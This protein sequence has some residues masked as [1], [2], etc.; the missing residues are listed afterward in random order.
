M[1]VTAYRTSK[2]CA[3]STYDVEQITAM[4]GPD[5]ITED[6]RK[7]ADGIMLALSLRDGRTIFLPHSF[8]IEVKED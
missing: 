5:E 3:T 2:Y 1:R 7:Y 6:D 4:P 8:L